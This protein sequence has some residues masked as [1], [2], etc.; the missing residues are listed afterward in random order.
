V[1]LEESIIRPFDALGCCAL[2]DLGGALGQELGCETADEIETEQVL[3]LDGLGQL[4]PGDDQCRDRGGRDGP[5]Q[6][7]QPGYRLGK[8]DDL[9]GSGQ[10]S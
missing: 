1:S 6:E 2:G 9:S 8:T 3:V 4:R 10:P 7:R 5:E